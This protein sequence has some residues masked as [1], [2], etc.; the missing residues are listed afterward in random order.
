MNPIVKLRAN[1]TRL[2]RLARA[3]RALIPWILLSGSFAVAAPAAMPSSVT[4]ALHDARIPLDSIAIVVQEIGAAQPVIARNADTP[5]NPA[6]LMKLVTTFVALEALGPAFT[7]KTEA[8]VEGEIKDET[9]AG[10]LILKGGGDP[11][12]TLESFWLMLRELRQKGIREIKGDLVIDRTLFANA[13]HDAGRFDEQPLRAYNVGPD[14]LLLNFKAVRFVLTPDADA[15]RVQVRADPPLP[16]LTLRSTLRLSPGECGDWKTNARATFVNGSDHAEATFAGTYAQACGEQSWN[17]SLMS[18]V[19]Y[20]ANLFRGL[21]QESGGTF[22]GQVRDGSTG[23]AA[24]LV[25]TLTSPQLAEIVRDINKFSNNVM[26]RQLFLTVDAQ[27]NGAPASAERAAATVKSLLA[28]RGLVFP[29]LAIENGAGLSRSDRISA[30]HLTRLLQTAF[31]SAVMP[32]FASSLP[33][34]AADGTMRKRLLGT[35]AAGQAHIKTGSLEGVRAQAG[36][37]LDTNGRRWSVVAIVNHPNAGGAQPALDG[38]LQWVASGA[39][40]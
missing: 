4:G 38:L 40:R 29:E 5:M 17:L 21:W 14:A 39:G 36:Y 10:N 1:P 33:L 3:S 26:A 16:G 12:V 31:G 28:K 34:T 2:R 35:A 7:W 24:R 37:V 15:R 6:S 9:L 23:P 11:K 30:G 27:A 25:A 22:S 8:Y 18:P 13:A 19:G 20:A 32:E